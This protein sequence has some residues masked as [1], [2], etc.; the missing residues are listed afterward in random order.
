MSDPRLLLIPAPAL[1]HDLDGH[2]ERAA[3]VPAILKAIAA[4][5]RTASLPRL[6][7]TPASDAQLLRVHTPEHLAFL[8]R[9][10]AEAPAYIDHA[11]TYITAG[12]LAAARL[13][14]GGACG[15]VDALLDGVADAG[16]AL[17]RPP[18]HHAP[19][20]HAMGFCLFNNVA[21]AARHAQARGLARV[22]IVDFDVHHGNGTQDVF[23]GDPSVLFVSTH[24]DGI[25]PL[26]GAIDEIGVGNIC[27]VPLP[28]GAGV[29][30]FLRIVDEIVAPLARRF[31]PDLLLVSAGYD[32][33]WRDP[34]A[35]LQ[36]T[37]T[38]YQQLV[39]R[40][41]DVAHESC[42]HRLGLVL[43]GGYDLEALASGV[44]ASL[45][46]LAGAT[47]DAPDPLGPAPRREPGVDAM[48]DRV[49]RVQRL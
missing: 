5:A 15:L 8:E 42:N 41:S 47:E 17:V 26:T 4:D 40:L 46:G 18:G 6:E 34:L 1:E 32:A 29:T 7:P 11:P 16:F 13:A 27:N 20:E 12:S 23:A 2:P 24:E 48:L 38:G 44:V 25:Y 36:M 22:M 28:A 45:Y 43:E 14:A 30:A 3:R 33:H 37:T 21:I 19:P 10:L 35:G 31:A 39:G 9:A 49:K